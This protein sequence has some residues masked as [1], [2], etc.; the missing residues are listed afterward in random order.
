MRTILMNL[1]QEAG[2]NTDVGEKS[3]VNVFI[4][5]FSSLLS[6]FGVVLVEVIKK[7]IR[8]LTNVI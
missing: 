7:L 8:F 3:F 1:R 6:V 4:V 2:Q 5:P